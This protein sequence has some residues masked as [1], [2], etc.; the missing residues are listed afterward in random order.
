VSFT[1]DGRGRSVRWESPSIITAFMTTKPSRSRTGKYV[2]SMSLPTSW[3]LSLSPARENYPR[4]MG[5]STD[6]SR[7]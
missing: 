2:W 5:G 7:V 3:N 1:G 6:D 4:G